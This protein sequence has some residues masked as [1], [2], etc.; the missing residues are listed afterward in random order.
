MN[1]ILKQFLIISVCFLIIWWFQSQDD[2]K[3]KKERI[4]FYEKF[5]FPIL[6][7]AII[8]LLLNIPTL[9]GI[10]KTIETS[11]KITIITPVKD[12]ELAKPFI[13]KNNFGNNTNEPL[14]WF[15]ESKPVSDQQIF[16][17]LPDF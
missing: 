16:T 7:S 14:S 3:N 17:D 10:D 5:K 11:A 8:G 6:V 1:L 9:F 15:P 12:C 4:T 2:K 13:H